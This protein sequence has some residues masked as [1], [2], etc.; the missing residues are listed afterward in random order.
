MFKNDP[1][2]F[3]G[4]TETLWTFR[5][6]LNMVKALRYWLQAVGLTEEPPAGRKVQNFTNFGTVVYENDPYFEKW[7]RCGFFTINL[8]LTK[9]MPLLGTISLTNLNCLS[10]QEMTLWCN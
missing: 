8:P 4:V 9:R 2:V 5:Y 10:L 6:R 1:Q 7:V 3:M